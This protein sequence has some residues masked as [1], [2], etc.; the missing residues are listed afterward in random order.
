MAK[1][2]YDEGFNRI[3]GKTEEPAAAETVETKPKKASDD[4]FSVRLD[5]EV[6]D[7]V[8]DFAYT[9]RITVK[10]ALAVMVNKFMADYQ[11]DPENEP[12]LKHKRRGE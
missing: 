1:K 5:R 4:M 7:K 10:E 11:S 2:N 6:A 9:R 12:L 8:R 3:L